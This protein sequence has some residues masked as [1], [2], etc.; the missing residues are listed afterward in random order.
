M[1]AVLRHWVGLGLD[2]FMLDAPTHY[3]G[4]NTSATYKGVGCS[5]HATCDASIIRDVIQAAVKPLGDIAVMGETHKATG[6]PW[7]FLEALDGAIGHSSDV[8]TNFSWES[9]QHLS[10]TIEE[11]LSF[12]DALS[13]NGVVSRAHV[14]VHNGTGA[15]QSRLRL[16]TAMLSLLG[17]YYTLGS[18]GATE[19]SNGD[20]GDFGTWSGEA[21]MAKVLKAVRASTALH[22]MS[23]RRPLPVSGAAG[24]K[25]V[26]AALRTSADGQN[27]ALVLFNFGGS[28]AEILVDL[29]STGLKA[30]QRPRDLIET[31]MAPGAPVSPRLDWPTRLPAYGYAALNFAPKLI[32]SLKNDDDDDHNANTTKRQL[33]WYLEDPRKVEDFLLGNNSRHHLHISRGRWATS[34]LASTSAARCSR[35]SRTVLSSRLTP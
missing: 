25:G 15:A 29:S 32:S 3:V 28:E 31:T 18:T 12:S 13:R 22:P 30:G 19:V 6:T 27:A 35:S 4:A 26:Y 23:T 14:R 7:P 24:S 17:G 5:P 16:Q 33:R 1:Q 11:A 20:Y 21:E 9:P 8:F 10:A 2:G 34:L